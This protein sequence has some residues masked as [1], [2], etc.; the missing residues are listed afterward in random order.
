MAGLIGSVSPAKIFSSDRSKYVDRWR[1]IGPFLL[2]AESY[3][4]R[5]FITYPIGDDPVNGRVNFLIESLPKFLKL[6]GV[7][8]YFKYRILNASAKIFTAL[9]DAPQTALV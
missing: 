6:F 9:R 8:P 1:I 2:P 3:F 4:A 5:T 7:E